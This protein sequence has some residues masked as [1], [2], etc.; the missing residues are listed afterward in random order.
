M[1]SELDV[2]IVSYR[3]QA[4]LHRCLTSVRDHAPS[5]TAVWV[6][7]NDSRDG[8]V[9]MLAESFPSVQ[10]VENDR[11]VGFARATNAGIRSG[12]APYILVLNPDTELRAGTL[13][14]LLA[15]M[16]Q[17]PEVGVCG[18]RLERPDGRFDH[19]A[20]RAFP[21]ILGALG[22][23]SG[24]GQR[25]ERG[26]LAQYRAPAVE[27]G[28]VDAVNGAFMLFRRSALEEVGLF[29][30]GYWMYMEDLDVC[31]RLAQAGWTTWYEPSVT[32]LHVKGGSAGR[33]SPRL[34]LAF[35][36]GMWRFYRA[37]Y[38]CRRSVLVSGAVAV[39]ITFKML[40]ALARAYSRRFLASRGTEE[41]SSLG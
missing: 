11:N 13:A 3:C 19:A 4:L 14:Y 23:F 18:C 25:V 37:H 38:A 32:A 40:V 39:G 5:H 27:R 1:T 16:E 20:R 24:V 26:R 21:T 36:A 10:T 6:V 12:G 22:H 9:E 33:R 8:T 35:H 30:E 29:D 28:P 15:T 31:Y 34:E 41:T 7:D 17:H 2:V